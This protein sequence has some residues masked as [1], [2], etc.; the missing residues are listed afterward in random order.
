MQDIRLVIEGYDDSDA[1]E[2]AELAS[3]LERSLRQL[4]F[5]DDVRRPER[6]A[7]PGARGD[8]VA[9]AELV[10]AVSGGLPGLLA[11]VHAWQRRHGATL[12]VEKDGETVTLRAGAPEEQRE[13]LAAWLERH[14]ERG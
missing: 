13:L 2:R 14:D 6:A 8:A 7:P 4:D 10:V 12:T 5:V 11:A 1:R 9:W 3:N